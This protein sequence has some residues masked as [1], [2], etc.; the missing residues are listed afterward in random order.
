MEEEKLRI[1]LKNG[2]V[3]LADSA[4]EKMKNDILF[5]LIPLSIKDDS[6]YAM[7][8]RYDATTI[9]KEVVYNEN[10]LRQMK[11]FCLRMGKYAKFPK[12]KRKYKGGRN[13]INLIV[14]NWDSVKDQYKFSIDVSQYS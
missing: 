12:S 5:F 8:Y 11:E 4:S 10:I 6:M 14:A 13:I 7:L 9:S 3:L 1:V 2:E